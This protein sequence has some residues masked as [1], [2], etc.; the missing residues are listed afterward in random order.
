MALLRA[1]AVA[2]LVA[3]G[4]AGCTSSSTP[5][6][7]ASA[8][9]ST[10]GPTATASKSAEALPRIDAPGF[11]Q[12]IYPAPVKGGKAVRLCPSPAGLQR[13][14]RHFGARAGR[15]A[16]HYQT[17]PL[18]RELRAADRAIWRT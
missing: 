8:S 7:P 18:V 9:P 1:L 10:A 2:A 15:I 4:A 13:P 12:T 14:G 17:G 11:P 16:E 5:D 3:G 6:A